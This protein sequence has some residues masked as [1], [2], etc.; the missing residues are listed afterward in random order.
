[1][2]FFFMYNYEWK[3]CPSMEFLNQDLKLILTAASQHIHTW[4]RMLEHSLCDDKIEVKAVDE[5]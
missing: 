4:Q 2:Y 3:L 1:M 5:E